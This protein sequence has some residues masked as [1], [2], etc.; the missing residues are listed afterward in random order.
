MTVTL[1]H[2]DAGDCPEHLRVTRTFLLKDWTH[3]QSEAV[4]EFARRR[5][6]LAPAA[7]A[8]AAE[9]LSPREMAERHGVSEYMARRVYSECGLCRDWRRS[10]ARGRD[11]APGGPG[12][13]SGVLDKE[14]TLP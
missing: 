1:P 8:C 7:R 11:G 2:L 14:T 12:E 6:A 13:G 9:G 3:A 4:R 10:G 5:D